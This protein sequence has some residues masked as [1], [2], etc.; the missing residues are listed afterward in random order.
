M[1]DMASANEWNRGIIE[2][3]RE[4]GGRVGGPFEGARMLLLR[5]KVKSAGRSARSLEDFASV[6]VT[7]S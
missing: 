3:F 5:M 7:T 6:R 4:N 1:S 2:E